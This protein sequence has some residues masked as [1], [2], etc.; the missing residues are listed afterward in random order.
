M[1]RYLIDSDAVIGFLRGV[2]P[3]GDLLTRL[4]AQGETLCICSVVAAEVFT[5]ASPGAASATEEFLAGF[6]YVPT[7]AG[8]ARQAG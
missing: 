5:G 3:V 4:S 1:A 2:A 7:T 8:I 6:T